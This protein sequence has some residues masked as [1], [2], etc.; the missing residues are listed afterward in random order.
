MGA[1]KSLASEVIARD[2]VVGGPDASSEE[3]GGSVGSVG[4]GTGVVGEGAGGSVGFVG[5]GTGVVGEGAGGSVGCVG[6]GTGVV[7][8]GTGDSTV[9]VVGTTVGSS[10]VEVTPVGPGT[11]VFVSVG[12]TV[13]G[14]L[15]TLRD[16]LA[17]VVPPGP[18]AVRS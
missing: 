17:L 15:T 7:G 8:E 12:A 5:G 14:T 9:T 11:S 3:A 16:L 10:G 1:G 2:T 13:P 4:G 18:V 6:G